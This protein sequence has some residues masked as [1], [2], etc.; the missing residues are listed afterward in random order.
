ML[1]QG[2][3]QFGSSLSAWIQDTVIK[4]FS[5]HPNWAQ[6]LPVAT[7]SLARGEL[8]P[9]SDLDM[10]FLGPEPLV[11]QLVQDLTHERWPL[12]YRVPQ[13]MQDWTEGV[14]VQDIL[15]IPYAR[16][17]VPEAEP[18]L[19][20]QQQR[21]RDQ[22]LKVWKRSLKF[23]RQEQKSRNERY[24]SVSNYLEPNLK[25]GPGALR[26]A[27]QAFYVLDLFF[28]S[29][30]SIELGQARRILSRNQ[31]FYLELRQRLHLLGGMDILSAGEQRELAE[32]M[33]FA[34][35]GP[36]MQKLQRSLAQ[37]SFIHDWVM[38]RAMAS[39]Q[40]LGQTA[41]RRLKTLSEVFE[42]LKGDPS[43]LMQGRLRWEVED[44]VLGPGLKLSAPVSYKRSVGRQL[45]Q[46]FT[47][48]HSPEFFRALFRSRVLERLIPDLARVKGVVQHDHYHRFTVDAHLSQAL[49]EVLRVYAGPSTL[50]RLAPLVKE[51]DAQ[52]FRI[53]LWTA[54]YHDLAKGKGGDHSTKGEALVKRD[55]VAMGLSLRLTLEVAWMVRNHLTL[56]TAAFR[57]NS[58]EPST[59][60]RLHS[61]G[62]REKR[63]TRLAVFTAV[64][65]R[66]TNPEAWT[67]WKEQLLMD[68]VNS[69]RSSYATRFMKFLNFMEKQNISWPKEILQQM[70][71]TVVEAL[72]NGVVLEELN[73]LK[74]VQEDLALKVVKNSRGEIWVRFHRIQ[75]RPGL[76]LGF[77][78]SLFATGS[79]IQQ[80]SVRTWP[81]VGAYDWFHVRSQKTPAQLSRLLQIVE[82]E[83]EKTPLG[84]IP[85]VQ[86]DHVTL[87]GED[88]QEWIISFRG[89]DQRG[90]LLAAA[91]ALFD[92][93]LTIRWARVHTWGRQV[94]DVFAVDKIKG[95]DIGKILECLGL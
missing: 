22:G 55:F 57:M 17:L 20:E 64:D 3:L 53:L 76:F 40:R 46:A 24:D 11:L 48:N 29:S 88:D 84:P 27:Q 8:C 74:E 35:P 1:A 38:E 60:Q 65:I 18:F 89:R 28:A 54:L 19:T 49:K 6:S 33:G 80:S 13:N 14:D 39:S 71:P 37:V 45:N 95:Q 32:Q 83:I 34:E 5:Q 85:H 69:L 67:D 79:R 81:G 56:S 73:H 91:Q 58:Q 15:A 12:R 2:E 78:R 59:W 23:M 70:D 86:F 41:S 62:V 36:L 77:V 30:L 66:A 10:I 21:L 93:G 51:L 31:S 47:V 82:R 50:G 25:Y 16:A 44:S 94:D 61:L 7:G 4:A 72:P 92:L 90:L 68:L 9:H 87:V 63:L 43:V 42:A 26:D 75:D 52:D